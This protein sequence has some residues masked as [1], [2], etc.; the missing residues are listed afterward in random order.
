MPGVVVFVSQSSRPF[1]TADIGAPSA[2]KSTTEPGAAVSMMELRRIS[3]RSLLAMSAALQFCWS[4]QYL[5]LKE[6][7]GSTVRMLLGVGQA[8]PSA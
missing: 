8:S 5:N 6:T 4:F 1:M 7:D 2:L 3:P